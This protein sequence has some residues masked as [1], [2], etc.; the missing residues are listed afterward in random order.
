M[1]I[2]FLINN[3]YG[4][5]GTNR[6]VINLAQGLSA[7]H[8]VEIVSV[9]RRQ[10][11]AKFDIPAEVAIRPLVDL[12]TGGRGADRGNPLLAEPTEVVPVQEEFH[13]QYSRLSDRRI[14]EYL[15]QTDADVVIGTRSSLNIFV[16]R[17]GRED[18]V[19]VAQEHMTHLAIPVEV[20]E[21]MA[22]VYPRLDAITTVTEAD[23]RTFRENTEVPGVPLLCI[24]NSVPEPRLRRADP[25]ARLVI[26]AGRLDPV[27]RYD[28]LVEAFNDLRGE[29]PDW[30][31][32]I[33]GQGPERGALRTL[34]SELRATERILL[35][36][37]AAPLDPEWV[38]GSI[39]AVTSSAE[40][41][42]MTL[43]EAMRCGLPVVSTDCPVGP[44]EI[45]E[46]GVDGLLVPTGDIAGIADGLRRLMADDE[47]RARMADAA[48]ENARRYD[49]A[50][51][52]ERYAALFTEAAAARGL[53]FATGERTPAQT[54]AAAAAAPAQ[55]ARGTTRAMGWARR[56]WTPGA[57]GKGG[58]ALVSVATGAA[59]R[60]TGAVAHLDQ[61]DSRSPVLAVDLPAG[62]ETGLTVL[63]R[64]VGDALNERLVTLATEQGPSPDGPGFVR[65]T[66][67]LDEDV[68]EALYD[69]RWTVVVETASGMRS[70]VQAGLRDTRS[71]IDGRREAL[72]DPGSVRRIAQL[73]S[74]LTKEGHL[75]LRS[76][77]RESH[78]EY[79]S[80]EVTESSVIIEGV[81]LGA[82][83]QLTG[84]ARLMLRRRGTTGTQLHFD[85]TVDGSGFR[86]E[87][88]AEELSRA[89]L[90]RW[91]DWDCWLL[92]DGAPQVVAD[93]PDP[94]HVLDIEAGLRAALDSSTR[95]GF[96][97]TA[98]GGE[99]AAAVPAAAVA[100]PDT[101]GEPA[102]PDAPVRI[103]RVLDDFVEVK[104][105][106]EYP[107]V[108]LV[109][110]GLPG[111][112]VV[113]PT[114][115]IDVRPFCTA[116]GD[117]SIQVVERG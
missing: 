6:T 75:A 46:D 115:R 72:A 60:V 41:F 74:Y 3:I 117:L 65:L 18:C 26:G 80:V 90:N 23:A 39:A 111:L 58:L 64:E 4:I 76:L 87:V 27:K 50:A 48:R 28:L 68:R 34:I 73:T 40:S 85:G 105:V 53:S 1:K 51:I 21:E 93:A 79:R 44:R 36:G 100:G 43:V 17:F 12:R 47:L 84:Q 52:A 25:G 104:P 2:A 33:Y 59:L 114:A 78:A 11:R 86:F 94:E 81:L 101:D 103:G 16:A 98:L 67:V 13:A 30:R 19:R 66:A 49:P 24:P 61:G 37:S 10:E 42:G 99:T 108:R 110:Q 116:A 71:L 96:D 82:V 70:R 31:L 62:Q 15:E 56:F 69:G 92:P 91:E 35:M 109:D 83:P 106:Y 102:R 55:F 14:R 77:R 7:D 112:A 38:K 54:R 95:A 63:L 97:G 22:R 107:S 9:F 32:R 20:R 57:L 113:L 29:F 89:R 8:R 45:I 88:P 5:G